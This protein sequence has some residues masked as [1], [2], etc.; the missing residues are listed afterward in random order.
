MMNEDELR[1][2]VL[3]ALSEVAPEADF[4][5]VRDDI[6]LREQLDIDS[7]DYLNFII[8]LHERTGVD[9]PERDYVRLA[10]L[11]GCVAYLSRMSAA[12]TR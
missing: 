3:A 4:Q 5:A 11:R 1:Q 9:I 2:A 6:E 10:T 8:G 12:E 7:M